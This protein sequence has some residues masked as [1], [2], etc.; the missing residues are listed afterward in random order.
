MY[1]YAVR[2]RT[3]KTLFIVVGE[4][5]RRRGGSSNERAHFVF[6]FER[7]T[8]GGYCSENQRKMRGVGGSE[9][10]LRMCAV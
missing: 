6:T 9:F 3:M 1:N 10:V 7:R 2:V 8:T 5:G 4:D